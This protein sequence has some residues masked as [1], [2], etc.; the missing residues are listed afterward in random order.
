VEDCRKPGAFLA[1]AI[2]KLRDSVRKHMRGETREDS[3]DALLEQD[4]YGDAVVSD[5]IEAGNIPSVEET[6]VY[7]D[8][9]RQ[10]DRRIKAIRRANPRAG[11][12]LDAVW[13]R[14]FKELSNEEIAAA[15]DTRPENVSVLINRGLIKL[16]EDEQ[17]RALTEGILHH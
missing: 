3:L 7:A 14:Y 17:L 10:I 15:L 11:R 2:Q 12:Q 5:A 4:F 1:F 8:L 6:T 13:L 16:R 9:R